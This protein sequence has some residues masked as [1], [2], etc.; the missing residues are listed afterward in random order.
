MMQEKLDRIREPSAERNPGLAFGCTALFFMFGAVLG[1]LAKWLDTL[2]IDDTVWWQSII[3]RLGLSTVF[4]EMPVWMLIALIIAVFSRTPGRAAKNVFVFF[5]GMCLVYHL[6]TV[7][8]CHFNPWSYML[9]WYIITAASPL[10]A[11]ICWYGRGKTVP[12]IIIDVLIMAVFGVFCFSSG[13]LYF[14]IV[15]PA[16]A[17]FFIAAVIVLY[18]S[19]K[20]TAIAV[21]AGLVLSVLISPFV[22]H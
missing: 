3:G 5:V 9:I 15:N 12:S 21:P 1:V 14:G 18:A 4:S 7:L 11:A 2:A 13:W 10:L 6:Y 20:Q 8:I 22:P 19:P 17:L 16:Y